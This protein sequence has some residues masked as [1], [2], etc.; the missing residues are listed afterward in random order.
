MESYNSF[1]ETFERTKQLRYDDIQCKRSR[2][3]IDIWQSWQE[4]QC[5]LSVKRTEFLG[6]RYATKMKLTSLFLSNSVVFV[7]FS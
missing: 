5:N 3:S 6:Y 1:P 2:F 4:K 7:Q